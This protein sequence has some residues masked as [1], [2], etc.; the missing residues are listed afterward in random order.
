MNP[1]NKYLLS[2]TGASLFINAS[3][4]IAEVYLE[5]KDW[6]LVKEKVISE[7]LLQYRTES[8]LKRVYLELW[9][10]LNQLTDE[11]LELLIEGS[12]QEQKQILWFAICQRYAYI[13]EFA[14]EVVHEKFLRMDYS[15]T[16]YDYDVFFNRKADWHEELDN[17]ADST[18]QKIRS[19][20]FLMLRQTNIIS[21]EQHI[22]PAI[23]TARVREALRPEAPLSFQIFPTT[24]STE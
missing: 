12:P 20:L 3:V 17:I 2:F 1:P 16:D 11:Q 14:I 22:L 23:F 18:R 24:I 21:E 5:L 7:N 10:R 4:T 8:S 15:L 6:D 19:V 13:R 9:P